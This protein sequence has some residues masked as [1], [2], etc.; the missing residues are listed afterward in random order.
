MTN[1]FAKM[2]KGL[3]RETTDLKTIRTRSSLTLKTATKTTMVSCT[4]T[5][6]SNNYFLTKAGLARITFNSDVPQIFTAVATAPGNRGNRGLTFANLNADSGA[7]VIVIP[8][9]GD[10]WDSDLS[11]GS[12]KTIS[13]Q[14]AV[15]STGDFTLTS[16]QINYEE[17]S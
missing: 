17:A 3:I 16:D 12:S 11:V 9:K 8:T 1:Q 7:G 4:I 10:T 15:T 5:R 14:I 13:V 2:L 6:T